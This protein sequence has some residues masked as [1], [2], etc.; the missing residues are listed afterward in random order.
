MMEY[1]EMVYDNPVTYHS[2]IRCMNVR[3]GRNYNI[4][5]FWYLQ[6]IVESGTSKLLW[7]TTKVR[8][9]SMSSVCVCVVGEYGLFW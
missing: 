2:G 9:N 7:I 5:T 8:L 6:K 1:T 4:T 3:Q